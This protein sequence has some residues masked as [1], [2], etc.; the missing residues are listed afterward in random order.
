MKFK[1][2]DKVKIKSSYV[3]RDGSVI[4]VDKAIFTIE[5]ISGEHVYLQGV[6]YPYFEADDL[7]KVEEKEMKL[8]ETT[9]YK[10]P[11][12]CMVSDNK[13][14]WGRRILINDNSDLNLEYPYICVHLLDEER[15]LRGEKYIDTNIFKYAKPCPEYKAYS[16]PKLEWVLKETYV[17]FKDGNKL[18]HKISY[19]SKN[20][21]FLN[22]LYGDI[23]LET[24]YKK[25]TWLDGS[26][27][28]E[29]K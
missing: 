18:I 4:L 19:I 9:D 14:D 7:E 26:P 15:F 6:D 29:L 3:E 17:K 16:E 11:K 10:D 25:C 13:K 8:E 20:G 1:V 21:V 24:L 12:Y 22:N 2:G 23:D 5:K 28:G 27:C